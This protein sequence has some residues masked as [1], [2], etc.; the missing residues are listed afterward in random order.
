L[1]EVPGVWKKG[2]INPIYKKVRK[3]DKE[4]QAGEPHL[5]LGTDGTDLPG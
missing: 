3:G 5:C 2:N 4:L 1:G